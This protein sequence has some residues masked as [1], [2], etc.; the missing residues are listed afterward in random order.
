MQNDRA[1][2][3]CLARFGAFLFT[4][5][6]VMGG[7]GAAAR[8]DE[9]GNFVI[10]LGRDTTS[11]ESYQRTPARLEVNQ[12]GRTP[13]VGN[14][15]LVYEFTDGKATRLSFQFTPF[16]ATTPAQTAEVTFAADSARMR[17]QSGTAPPQTMAIK[18]PEGTV[19]VTNASPWTTYESQTM[20][21]IAS[22][23]ESLRT[24]L[25]FVGSQSTN[26]LEVNKLQPDSVA[27]ET[28]RGD[29]YHAR[30]D[31]AGRILGVRP[32][33]GP[34]Q[35]SVARVATLDLQAMGAAYA[36]REKAGTG[37][38]VLSPR[39]T[40]KVPDAGGAALTIDY[41]RPAKRGRVIFGSVVPYGEVWRTGANAATQFKTDKPLDFGGHVLP[42]GSYT[43]F[44]VPSATGWKLIVNSETGQWGTAHKPDKDLFRV[45]MQVSAVPQPVEQFTIGVDPTPQ[46]GVLRMEWD[47]TRA[48]VPFAVKR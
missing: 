39:D 22:K 19:V 20:K 46:G 21:L 3:D 34:A 29:V 15:R 16:G 4:V 28:D 5:T 36:A 32:V 42:A 40:V 35:Y 48:S 31:K 27:L 11:V 18:L 43:L 24:P 10:Q 17:N 44:T 26:W 37:L 47:T 2:L 8:A 30:V 14:R 6:C 1:G 33:A 38:G 7:L 23:G 45:D 25:W 13:R 41:S 12:V 9:T